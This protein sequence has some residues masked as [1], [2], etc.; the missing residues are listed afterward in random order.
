MNKK[1]IALAVAA[2]LAAPLVAQAGVTV[3]GRA[4]VELQNT[5]TETP[6]TSTTVRNLKDN[7]M[8]R[9]GVHATEDLGNGMTGIAH[10][11][12]IATSSPQGTASG[13]LTTARQAYIGLKGGFGTVMFGR[14]AGVYKGTNLDPFIATGLQARGTGGNSA[15]NFGHNGFINDAIKYVNQFGL[16]KISALITAGNNNNHDKYIVS[17]PSAP[18]ASPTV[19]KPFAADNGSYQFA[20]D[21]KGGPM[22]VIVA[23]SRHK[24]AT[25]IPGSKTEKRTQLAGQYKMGPN[26]F[27]GTYE[28][29]KDYTPKPT[30]VPSSS[31]TILY[32][33]STS[34]GDL[35]DVDFYMLSYQRSM[36]NHNTL[37][38]RYGH[39][40]YKKASSYKIK[41]YAV[42]FTHMMSRTFRVFA[43][44]MQTKDSGSKSDKV[45]TLT[46]GMRMDF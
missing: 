31:P 17:I 20:V 3:Y 19:T 38:V 29:V 39:E 9:I 18:P 24:N 10:F 30:K 36:A 41:S 13:A 32:I 44:A 40:N 35:G 12:Y 28:S 42:G 14:V 1:L 45:T 26:L 2:A 34:A 4:Q 27:S 22:R 8:A 46:A 7:K 25:G 33:P 6:T 15:G 23:Y 11:G 37:Y 16:V 21:Y 43:G 5:K